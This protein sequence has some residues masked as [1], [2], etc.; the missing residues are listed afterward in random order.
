MTLGEPIIIIGLEGRMSEILQELLGALKLP[1]KIFS[2]KA[3][4]SLRA[5]N[6]KNSQ[7]VIDFSKPEIFEKV[8]GLAMEA[9]VPFVCG[10]TG[11]SSDDF[12]QKLLEE[13]S[14]TI[15]VVW[16]SNFSQGIEILC[17][18]SELLSKNIVGHYSI[19]DIHHT[20]KKDSPS[21]T[22]H[23]I[24]SRIL[25]K[26]PKLPLEVLSIRTGEI[27]GEHR[28][29]IGFGD[30]SLELVHRAYSR[31]PFAE[32]ALKALNFAQKQQPGI[33]SMKD[34]L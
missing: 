28:V 15:P 34:V 5:E 8:I 2:P 17:Q 25:N 29:L 14:K 16:D 32:G 27:P 24:K 12:K 1:Y 10:T 9:K 4:D 23:K 18:M 33:Y 3:P 7:G 31:Q 30:E 19:T 20:H 22:A 11:F 21:G 6:F 13:A 26:N